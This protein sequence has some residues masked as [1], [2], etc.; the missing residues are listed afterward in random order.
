V[1]ED[2][3][4]PEALESVQRLVQGGQFGGFDA[5]DLFDSADVLLTDGLADAPHIPAFVGELDAHR[6]AVDAAAP[7]IE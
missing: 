2:L 5:A 6:A 3:I 7:V 4:G 1:I